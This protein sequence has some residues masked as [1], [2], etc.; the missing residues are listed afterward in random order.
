VTSVRHSTF[1]LYEYAREPRRRGS[2][3][4]KHVFET[5][6]DLLQPLADYLAD[7]ARLPHP[8]ELAR[9]AELAEAFGSVRAAAAVLRRLLGREAS[10]QAQPRAT[11]DLLVYLARP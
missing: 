8:D 2:A 4:P 1:L 9:R 3:S 7:R 11:S 6:R 10:E 5:H